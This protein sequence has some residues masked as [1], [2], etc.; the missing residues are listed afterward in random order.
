MPAERRERSQ[1]L[2]G[3]SPAFVGQL[4]HPLR[5]YGFRRGAGEVPVTYAHELLDDARQS[6]V[7]GCTRW[8][9]NP[10]Q[11]THRGALFWPEKSVGICRHW[12]PVLRM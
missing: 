7:S 2:D 3:K 9:V 12:Q 10:S 11:H 4:A 1:T 8:L 5:V 6:T